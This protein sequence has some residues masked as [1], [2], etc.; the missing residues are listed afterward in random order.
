MGV[1]LVKK[2]PDRHFFAEHQLLVKPMTI[3]CTFA[4]KTGLR[5]R[6]PAGRK[7]LFFCL[8]R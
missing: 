2:V 8:T 1:F 5:F 4:N 7:T 6:S 3:I